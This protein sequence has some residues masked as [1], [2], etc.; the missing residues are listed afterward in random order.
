MHSLKLFV[1]HVA[2]LLPSLAVY[3]IDI[4]ASKD[5][6]EKVKGIDIHIGIFV[7]I[8]TGETIGVET[9]S[10][11]QYC[12]LPITINKTHGERTEISFYKTSEKIYDDCLDIVYEDRDDPGN[13]HFE[14]QNCS[15]TPT[16]AYFSWCRGVGVS[17]GPQ[18]MATHKANFVVTKNS[19]CG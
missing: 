7:E 17:M 1:V 14:K 15:T 3:A 11:G 16:G 10:R 9:D 2:L 4:C 8:F 6:E 13:S 12:E 18:G 19:L 5:S